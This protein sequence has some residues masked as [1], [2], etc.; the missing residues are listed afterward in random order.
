LCLLPPTTWLSPSGVVRLDL[1]ARA[2]DQGCQVERLSRHR[3][4]VTSST[5][6]VEA[7]AYTV[8]FAINNDGDR[9]LRCTCPA[10]QHDVPCKHAALV[11]IVAATGAVPMP[12]RAPDAEE[13]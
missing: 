3:W 6:P 5:A 2:L 1:A 7:R 4:L 12:P 11:A 13:D 10:G 8:A 9:E